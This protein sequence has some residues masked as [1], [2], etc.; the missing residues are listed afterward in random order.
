MTIE[1]ANRLFSKLKPGSFR[2]AKNRV[3]TPT[4]IQMEAVECGAAALAIILGYHGLTMPL[5]QLRVICGVSRDGTKASNLVKA[6]RTFGLSAKGLKK[7]FNELSDLEPPYIVFWNFNH[8]LVVEGIGKKWYYL[9]DPATGP[10]KVGA[11]EFDQSFTGV[12]LAFAKTPEFKAGG[13]R[14]SLIR[15]LASRLRTNKAALVYVTLASLALVIPG[16][17][18]PVLTRVFIDNYLVR[19]MEKWVK[20]VLL[21]MGLTALLKAALTHVQLRSLLKLEN[22]MSVSTTSNFFWHVLKLPIE[23]FSQRASG[24]IV[25]RIEINDRIAQILSGDLAINIAN[26]AMAAFYAFLMFRFDPTLTFIGIGIAALNLVVLRYVSRRRTDANRRLLQDQ[27]KLWG[28]AMAGLLMIETLK[29]TGSESDFF[30]R[31]SG[32]HAKVI[33][34]E[35][36]L[37]VSSQVLATVPPLLSG[38]LTIFILGIGG[39]HVIDG[40]LT[41][42][43]LVAFQS[44]MDGFINPVR[45]LTDLGSKFQTAEG[46]MNRLDDVLR[47][48]VDKLASQPNA[49]ASDAKATELF[50]GYI[51]LRDV[52]F[53]YNRLEA[54]LIQNFDMKMKPGDRIAIVGGSGSGKSTLAKLIAGL[55]EPWEGQ[56][57]FDGKPRNAYPRSMITGSLALVDQ[58]IFLFEG[59]VK[60]NISFWDSTLAEP[61]L[62]NAAKDASIHEEIAGRGGY[63][64]TIEE[65]GRNF[66]GGQRQRLEIARALA[67]NPRILILDEATAALDAKTEEWVATA[68]R[69]RGCTA[70]IIAHRLSTIRD[71]DEIIVLDR[72]KI[73]ERGT[74]SQLVSAEGVYAKLI[75][76]T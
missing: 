74:H 69:R 33:N 3:R 51:E 21:V 1:F 39:F 60:E 29:S 76:S 66:S 32:N 35:Q 10:R 63:N 18:A 58:D 8:F 9:N 59:S 27:G 68:I 75:Q 64:S 73:A 17:V 54:P 5:E 25:A 28:T 16:L 45:N 12:I 43:M 56:I 23:F 53:G 61:R 7:E 34:A 2:P 13:R 41:M 44:L 15:A 62:V 11:D 6:A 55:Y 57:L 72:G 20:P 37:G 70:V 49:P 38:L 40:I 67:A 52:A 30:A 42:G 50:E 36:R 48:P 24:E 65:G 19:G 14:P 22:K 47:Y 26:L 71:C 31:W 4:V 46:E